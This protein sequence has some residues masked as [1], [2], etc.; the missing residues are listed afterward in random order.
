MR[1]KTIVDEDFVNYK[2]PSMFIGTIS[3]G[4]KCCIEGG[5]PL[6]VCQNDGWRGCAPIN[7]ADEAIVKRY[8]NNPITKSIVLGGMEP[9]EQS[10]EVLALIK[11]L[12]DDYGCHDD[13]VIY[14]GYYP[15]EVTAILEKLQSFDNIVVKFGRYIPNIK[16]RFDDVLG[17]TLV[18][19]NQYAERIS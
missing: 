16:S 6:S 18:S 11:T 5:F 2:K 8:L 4:G 3:C 10:D 17:V 15:D 7:I 9:M 14:T 13:V 19:E 12:R 1:V